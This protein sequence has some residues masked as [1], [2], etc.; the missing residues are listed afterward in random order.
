MDRKKFYTEQVLKFIKNKD[1]QILVLGAGILDK[2]IFD[3]IGYR[4]VTFSNIENSNEKGL[5]FN[6]NIHNIK[7]DSNAY[8]YCIAHACIHHSSKPHTAILELYRVCSKGSLI[9]EANDSLISRLACKFKL[10]EEYELSA[11]KK[12]ETKG[13]VDNTNIPN[14]VYRWT[15]REI[16]KLLKSYRPDLKHRIFF[17]YGSHSTKYV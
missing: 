7:I 13:G 16:I 12:N 17:N 9:I 1:S 11:V 2:S 14:Y 8:E 6:E 15:E 10:S 5:N 3:E 4:N